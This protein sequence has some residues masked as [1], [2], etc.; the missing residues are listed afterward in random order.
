MLAMSPPS[1]AQY[2]SY[3][4]F[5][6]LMIRRPPRSTLF[7]YTTLFR[8]RPPQ[9]RS[10]GPVE[11]P[12]PLGRRPPREIL[13][14]RRRH[15]RAHHGPAYGPARAGHAERRGAGDERHRGGRPGRRFLRPGRREGPRP[16]EAASR[17]RG[18]LLPP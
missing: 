15:V 3:V 7:P 8:S 5:F 1:H 13:R 10:H 16:P 11:G 2:S 4:A 17:H 9:D 18:L 12:R 6:F 14:G